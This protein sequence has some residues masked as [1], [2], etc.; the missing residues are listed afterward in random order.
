MWPVSWCCCLAVLSS[1]VLGGSGPLPVTDHAPVT[2]QAH[3]TDQA[4]VTDQAHVTDQAPVTEQVHVTDK[5]PVT[6]QAP[7]PPFNGE[8]FVRLANDIRDTMGWIETYNP[9]WLSA[10]CKKDL[11]TF[12]THTFLTMNSTN[13]WAWRSK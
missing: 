10:V 12:S 4:P 6:D 8:R 1:G 2:D 9:G 5:A 7:M 13:E 3:V 11:Y